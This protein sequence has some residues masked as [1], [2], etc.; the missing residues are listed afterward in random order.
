MEAPRRGRPPAS[1]RCDLAIAQA[2]VL[3]TGL[4]HRC[5]PRDDGPPATRERT[6]AGGIGGDREQRA[7]ALR[8]RGEGR[9]LSARQPGARPAEHERVAER[10]AGVVHDLHGN[11]RGSQQPERR[12]GKVCGVVHPQGGGVRAA[13]GRTGSS[14]SGN[15]RTVEGPGR[16]LGP[17]RC[18]RRAQ[19]VAD[20]SDDERQDEP[21][22]EPAAEKG[23][24]RMDRADPL[25]VLAIGIPGIALKRRAGD[26]R[27]RSGADPCC[28]RRR[29]VLLPRA[30]SPSAKDQ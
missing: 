1:Q 13:A 27:R 6:P 18:A 26:T 4:G 24:E 2:A 29:P 8:V 25:H 7:P 19:P 16:E 5:E 9:L 21:D 10:G 15:D 23:D 17:G 3:Q 30:R 11:A 28:A 20:G 22:D 12:G 14:G